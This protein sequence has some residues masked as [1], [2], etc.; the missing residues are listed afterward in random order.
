MDVEKQRNMRIWIMGQRA[1]Q[2]LLIFFFSGVV[3]KL[4]TAIIGWNIL[5]IQPLL[6]K[7]PV[8]EEEP[9][10][11]A[12][13]DAEGGSFLLGAKSHKQLK[14]E[15][16]WKNKLFLGNA[17]N[18][19]KSNVRFAVQVRR[20]KISQKQ[21]IGMWQQDSQQ[22]NVRPSLFQDLFFWP[23]R[24][25]KAGS[26]QRWSI[27]LQTQDHGGG[28]S[29]YWQCSLDDLPFR[30][31]LNSCLSLKP[32]PF[33]STLSFQVQQGKSLL[34]VQQKLWKGMRPKLQDTQWWD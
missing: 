28:G 23:R 30:E 12:I 1:K 17:M 14:I 9:E 20:S 15:T 16:R 32:L 18:A 27:Q 19:R 6:I 34:H 3:A 13:D 31:I 8:W 11:P 24:Q 29:A 10:E 26:E 21:W 33:W 5:Q 25:L 22:K 2:S 4:V 7:N